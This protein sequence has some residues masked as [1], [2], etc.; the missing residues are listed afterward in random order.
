MTSDRCRPPSGTTRITTLH[1][2]EQKHHRV[3]QTEET[4]ISAPVFHKQ[5]QDEAL[6]AQQHQTET[7]TTCH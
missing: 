6:L 1:Y 7:V 5:P 4:E 2:S 3:A